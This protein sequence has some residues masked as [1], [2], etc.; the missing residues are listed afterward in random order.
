MVA[1]RRS[2]SNAVR[3]R[4][5]L[6]LGGL[7]A[8]GLLAGCGSSESN[9]A[10]EPT[11]PATT[12]SSP[13]G[14]PVVTRSLPTTNLPS[15]QAEWALAVPTTG[16]AAG[17]VIVL[18]GAG[19]TGPRA[20]SEL[21]LATHVDATGLALAA[22]SGGN[23]WWHP[24]DSDGD[25]L[26]L[27]ID[28]LIPAALAATGLPDTTRVGLLGYSMGG[29]GALLVGA[30]LGPQRVRAIVAQAPAL[31]T[32][33]RQAGHAFDSA[34]AFNQWS[35]TGTR[36]DT[37]RQIPVWID[38]GEEDSFIEVSRQLAQALPQAKAT[39]RPGAH[40]TAVWR[41]LVGDELAWIADQPA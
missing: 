26:A 19:H 22:P 41:P 4:E 28:D 20:F 18:H 6:A 16:S 30:E 38:C 12:A 3:R 14:V 1:S 8:F 21:A 31:F 25:G 15:G 10:P 29:Y 17:L 13:A 39:F 7:T 2:S 32:D 33:P 24:T 27:V 37:L 34:D 5:V 40:D 11:E 23:T 35:I 9:P 36:I